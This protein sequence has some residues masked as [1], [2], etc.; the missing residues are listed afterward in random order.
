MGRHVA[1]FSV[2]LSI[3]A[4]ACSSSDEPASSPT[5]SVD[6]SG[7]VDEYGCAVLDRPAPELLE[8]G[9]VVE[10]DDKGNSHEACAAGYDTA[11]PTTGTHFAVWQNCG[12]YTEP[13]R[14]NAA[15]HSLE[16]GAVWISYASDLTADEVEAIKTAVG[17]DE[18]MLAAPYPG[19]QNPIVLSAWTRQLAV[20]RWAD[21]L[22][23]EFI[24][25]YLGRRSPTAPEPGV[26][27]DG[28]F[29]V[30]PNLPDADYAPSLEW[31]RDNA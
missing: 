7:E 8:V 31:A 27:C 17:E 5:T 24:H 15:V 25:D 28:G 18:H 9:V 21:P 16:H 30:A 29:G 10:F 1:V 13:I 22:V 12:F 14:D 11:I 19:L 3:V 2:V 4:G 23:A 20:D 6:S 26:S